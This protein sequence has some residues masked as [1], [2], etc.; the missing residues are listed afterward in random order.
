MSLAFSI[1]V[2]GRTIF[3]N[4]RLDIYPNSDYNQFC[5]EIQAEE[6]SF[7]RLDEYE[8]NELLTITQKH[9]NILEEEINRI[10]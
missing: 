5:V 9:I 1:E 3:L 7:L 6:Q 10:L 4:H 2:K 8:R